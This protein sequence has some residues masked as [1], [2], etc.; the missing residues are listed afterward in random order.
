VIEIEHS[1]AE[2]LVASLGGGMRQFEA[3]DEM[4]A[5]G[6]AGQVVVLSQV[7]QVVGGLLQVAV[8]LAELAAQTGD[9]GTDEGDPEHHHREYAQFQQQQASPVAVVGAEYLAEDDHG[10]AEH[11]DQRHQHVL[12]LAQLKT[13][14]ERSDDE[15]HQQDG[16]RLVGMTDHVQCDKSRDQD[17]ERVRLGSRKRSL[18]PVRIGHMQE[19]LHDQNQQ[20]PMPS[21]LEQRHVEQA[22]HPGIQRQGESHDPR[23]HSHAQAP[24][25]RL[26]RSRFLL[27]IV[28]ECSWIIGKAP[29]TGR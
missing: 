15:Q 27:V 10:K 17:V 1:H 24:E 13:P 11:G 26:R 20:C 6:Q 9:V 8:V 21:E 14:E 12:F 16:S 25:P 22:Q 3:G 29:S 7:L 23:H 2:G 4:S 18:Q 19:R 28:V 5:V